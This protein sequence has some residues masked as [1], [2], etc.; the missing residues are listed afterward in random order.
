M[1]N[2]NEES[3]SKVIKRMFRMA[4][5]HFYDEVCN[6]IEMF[7]KSLNSKMYLQLSCR[8]LKSYNQNKV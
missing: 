3:L 1:Q 4:K 6:E 8:G 5:S 7:D 2:R